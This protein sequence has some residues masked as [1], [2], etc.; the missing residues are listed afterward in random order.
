[1]SVK[2]LRHYHEVG[3]L[4]PSEVDPRSGYRYYTDE[5]LATAQVI[6]RLRDLQMPIADVKAVLVAPDTEIRNRLIAGHLERLETELAQTRST[7]SELRALLQRPQQP[8]LAIS[9]RTVP[10]TA[11]IAI[12]RTVEL[13]EIVAWWQGALAELDAVLATRS[14]RAT[15][16]PSGIYASEIFQQGRGNAIVFVPV[17]TPPEDP[18]GRVKGLHIPGAELAIALHRGSLHNADLTYAQL[19]RHALRHEISIDG[20]L[21]E[22]YLVGYVDTTD[23]KRWQTEIGWPI[24]RS[25]A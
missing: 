15:G 23:P 3:L 14:L 20:P 9:R 4:E 22:H 1:L 18:I 10:A 5:Q 16:P 6:R 13:D 7:V 12:E 2:T 17:E 21:R 25:G 11:A 24:F 8:L 19:A